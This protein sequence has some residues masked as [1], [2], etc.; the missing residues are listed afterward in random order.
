[1]ALIAI[2]A[3]LEWKAL[4]KR[5]SLSRTAASARFCS[6]TSAP[7]LKTSTTCPQSLNTARLVQDTLTRSPLRRMF[8][9][10]LCANSS[11]CSQMRSIIGSSSSPSRATGGTIVPTTWRPM[12]SPSE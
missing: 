7:T 2:A 12:S 8:S 6:V 10:T 11:G 5:S 3:G 1:M 9:L 4:A